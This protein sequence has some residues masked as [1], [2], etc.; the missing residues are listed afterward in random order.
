MSGVDK[1]GSASLR[2]IVQVL[3]L[4][5][6]KLRKQPSFVWAE[7][8]G[9]SP[10]T[11][12]IDGDDEPLSGSPATTVAGL[13]VGDRVYC[14]RQNGRCTII[15]S[16]SSPRVLS[17]SVVIS[18]VANSWTG[19]GI[20]FPAGYFTEPP[21]VVASADSGSATVSNVSATAITETSANVGIVRSNTT[22]TTVRWVAVQH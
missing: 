3:K 1:P 4:V 22:A 18:P 12:R 8:A 16:A 14:V 7:V 20:T 19:A 15:G 6:E 17:G 13:M 21:Q 2:P 11:I 10:L 5:I 9:T